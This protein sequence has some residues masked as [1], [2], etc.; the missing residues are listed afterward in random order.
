MQ[1]NAEDY[2]KAIKTYLH[3]L[4][5]IT[6]NLENFKND[7]TILLVLGDLANMMKHQVHEYL[8]PQNNYESEKNIRAILKVI[9][10][11]ILPVCQKKIKFHTDTNNIEALGL[12]KQLFK[13]FWALVAFR[14]VEHFA[15]YMDWDRTPEKKVW[16]YSMPCMRG[17]FYHANRMILGTDVKL[18]RA[19]CPV[20]YGK[21]YAF[22]TIAVWTLGV[23]PYFRVLIITESDTL[24]RGIVRNCKNMI[25]SKEF[26]EVF[27]NFERYEQDEAKIFSSSTI[28]TLVLAN[29]T[30]TYSLTA[31]TRLGSSN[32]LRCDLLILDD[33]TKGSKDADNI[34]LH[35]EIVSQYDNV[36]NAR[37]DGVQNNR[38][39]AGGTMWA[40]YDLLNVIR[41]RVEDKQK[42]TKDKLPYTEISEDGNFIF[43]GVPNLDYDTD[44]STLPF[45]FPTDYLRNLRDNILEPHMWWARCQQKPLPP[46]GL[47]FDWN[48]FKQYD[49]LPKSDAHYAVLDP[50]RKGKNYV[51]MM[52]FRKC[53]ELSYLIDII[54]RK[55][56]MKKLHDPIVDKI[57]KHNIM[58]FC[59]ENN[60]DTSLGDL[61]KTKLAARC[62]KGC[63]IKSVFSSEVKEDKIFLNRSSIKDYIIIPKKGMYSK[64]SEMGQALEQITTYSFE[65]KNDYDD[66][67]E[68]MAMYAKYYCSG[69]RNSNTL[70]SFSRRATR[71]VI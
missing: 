28:D 46:G 36:W 39:L 33:L 62:Y 11:T 24:V 57:T 35:N 22:N 26:S 37:A 9:I 34:K 20:S 61:I 63:N 64:Q 18:I 42:I 50:A 52:I 6:Q 23:R 16:E 3:T 54:F 15:Y 21:T 68:T 45:K 27:P 30:E 67:I 13:K 2:G 49:T 41:K 48:E 5:K 56:D 51:C 17:I 44:E 71:K 58:E 14:S 65:R 60:T 55:E 66:A 69:S 70:E 19:S 40:D 38:I 7:E 59:F 47:Y 1:N 25:C 10:K 4:Q 32:G 8:A 53:G 29:S 43:V 12:Y 31:T